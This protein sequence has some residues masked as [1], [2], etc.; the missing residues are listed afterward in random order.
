MNCQ[1]AGISFHLLKHTT[2]FHAYCFMTP[3]WCNTMN[4]RL[5][6]TDLD[7]NPL[8]KFFASVPFSLTLDIPLPLNYI[9]FRDQNLPRIINLEKLNK[10]CKALR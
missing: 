6:A 5:P 9:P 1:P 3:R 7:S 2:F 10:K 4:V 8:S